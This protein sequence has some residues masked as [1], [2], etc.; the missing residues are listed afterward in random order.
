MMSHRV[1]QRRFATPRRSENDIDLPRLEPCMDAL[2]DTEARS[3]TN[4]YTKEIVLEIYFN[5]FCIESRGVFDECATR[6]FD[7]SVRKLLSAA[8]DDGVDGK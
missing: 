8:E 6:L 3:S 5:T 4:A 7:F 2:Y 1:Q